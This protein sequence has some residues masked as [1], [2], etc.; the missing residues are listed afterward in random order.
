MYSYWPLDHTL[1]ASR[2]PCRQGANFRTQLVS[3]LYQLFGQLINVVL[4][5]LYTDD[6]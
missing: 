1:K 5:E 6:L 4:I 3:Y 2:I